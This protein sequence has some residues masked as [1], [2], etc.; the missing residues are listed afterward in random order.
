[1]P[2]GARATVLTESDFTLSVSA[3]EGSSWLALDASALGG[4]FNPHRCLCPDTIT[5]TLQ[6]TS[7]GQTNMSTSTVGVSF[8]LGADCS[9]SSASCVS[10]GSATFTASQSAA[11]P[12][13]NSSQ[14]FQAAAGISAVNC[15]NLGVGS[16][17]L[18][19]TLTQDGAALP[20]TLSL[21][22]PVTTTVVAAPTAVAALR[23][24]QHRHGQYDHDRG[25]RE[26][27]LLGQGFRRDHIGS[28]VR[29]GKWHLLHGRGDR[30]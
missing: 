26:S 13:F 5:P 12:T 19:A 9:A 28:F 15:A 10:L 3:A 14:V 1:V 7:S 4:F 21:Q 8:F 22:I 23:V 6:L 30:H 18:W 2:N 27:G 11:P 17:T 29:I 20:F 16:T 24:A 25:R